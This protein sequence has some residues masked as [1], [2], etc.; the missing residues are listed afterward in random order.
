VKTESYS[1]AALTVPAAARTL[2]VSNKT[3]HR[4]IERHE[5]AAFDVGLADR[6]IWRI[7]PDALAEF[8]TRRSASKRSDS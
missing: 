4:L 8:I 6:A 7:S 2:G 5:L 3:I 1:P